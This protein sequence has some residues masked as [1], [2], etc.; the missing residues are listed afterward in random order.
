MKKF[1]ALLLALVLSLISVIPVSAATLSPIQIGVT[2]DGD[3]VVGKTM[4]TYSYQTIDKDMYVGRNA[5]YAF[6]GKLT[7]KGNLYVLGTFKNHGTVNVH[8]DIICLNY[9]EGNVLVKRASNS[10]SDGTIQ[11]FDHGRFYNYGDATSKSVVTD[12]KY[13]WIDP[14]LIYLKCEHKNRTKATCTSSSKCLDCGETLSPALGHKWSDWKLIQKATVFEPSVKQT[15]CSRCGSR[16]KT[17]G[18]DVLTPTGTANYKNVTLKKGQ[19]T[20]SV[21]IVGMANG[22]YL[23]DVAVKNKKL[24]KI[25]NV[26]P[27]GTFKISAL[28][29][30]GKTTIQ[31]KLA[32]GKTI[33]INVKVQ[34]SSV[35][36]TNLTVKKDKISISKGKSYKIKVSKTP[37]TS[38]SNISFSTSN[39]KVAIVSKNGTVT[40]LKKGTA[41]IT[42]KS[43]NVKKKVKVSVK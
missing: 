34:N 7:I 2:D 29:I 32:S 17:E 21:K 23:A 35:S 33:N 30:T 22:D 39:K 25:T 42:I 16:I 43:G 26:K 19:A 3:Y 15:K 13:A 10:L 31:V 24:I 5:E 18:N 8:G 27:N 37:F 28:K 6:Y 1:K 20:S 4:Q 41:Y 14:P 40:G 12:A 36:T 38:Q 9:Y 11:V